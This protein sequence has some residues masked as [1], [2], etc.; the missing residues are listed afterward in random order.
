[1]QRELIAPRCRR[2]GLPRLFKRSQAPLPE[3]SRLQL[4]VTAQCGTLDMLHV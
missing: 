3:C 4:L 2:H 1:M